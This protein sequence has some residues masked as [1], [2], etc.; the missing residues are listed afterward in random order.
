[1]KADELWK[2]FAETGSPALY[3]LY[4]EVCGEKRLPP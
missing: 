2:L 4:R 1:M 3:L